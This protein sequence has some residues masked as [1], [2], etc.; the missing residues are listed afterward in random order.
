MPL[1][2]EIEDLA[3][4]RTRRR[5]LLAVFAHP[6]DES[7]ACAGAFARA[8]A[9]PDAAAVLLCLTRGEASSM[10]RERGLTPEEVA[11]LRADRLLEVARL[12]GLDALLV[13]SYPDGRLARVDPRDVAGTVGAVIAA[14]R[15]QVVIG[16]CPRGVN[17]HPD[18]IAAHW[19]VRGALSG[20]RANGVRFAMTVYPA[21]T[22]EAVKPYLLFPT[23]E[24]E[25]D[26]TLRLTPEEI[27]V[28]EACLRVHEGIVTL[29]EGGDPALIRRPPVEHYDFLGEDRP[30]PVDDLFAPPLQGGAGGETLDGRSSEA[31]P[32]K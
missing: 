25:I 19:A 30:R 3:A 8:A 5:R 31:G 10:G 20:A 14:L 23:S 29:V 26:A 2:R 16:S 15:P 9:D 28:K 11:D 1:I 21:E 17:G 6:D 18:H 32:A 4:L 7:Y 13:G 12:T 22:C 24:S 27:E